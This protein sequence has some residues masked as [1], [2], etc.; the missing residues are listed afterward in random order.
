MTTAKEPIKLTL[1]GSHAERGVSL[2]SFESFIEY[3]L[4]ALRAF[5]REQAGVPASKAGTPERAAA[6]AT[7]FRLVQ[8]EPGSAIATLEPEVVDSLD[9]SVEN[10]F[11]HE[12]L[13]MTNLVSLLDRIE[14][15]VALPPSVA[16]SLSGACRA[17]GNDGSIG[18][19]VPSRA[20][21]K[22]G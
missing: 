18:V 22:G 16:D 8:L 7:A 9:E 11:D 21:R 19:R 13:Q 5:Q 2:S 14:E 15:Q 17:L 1:K 10:M 6:V 20:A 12:P 4:A 3:F